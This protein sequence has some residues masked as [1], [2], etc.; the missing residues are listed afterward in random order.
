MMNRRQLVCTGAA[1]AR[2]SEAVIR[3]PRHV[4][5]MQ[6]HEELR[7]TVAVGFASARSGPRRAGPRARGCGRHPR[8]IAAFP[9]LWG[10]AFAESTPDAI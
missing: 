9:G 6:P 8:G 3:S 5:T 4:V 1:A 10:I 7:A 2:K